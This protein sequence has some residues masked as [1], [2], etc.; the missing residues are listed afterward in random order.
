M[1]LVEAAEIG[2]KR[3]VERILIEGKKSLNGQDEL[4]A[5]TALI[6]AA[7]NGHKE[8]CEMILPKGCNV[9][10]QNTVF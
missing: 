4:Y 8:I 6:R 9:D 7:R 2:D 3:E 1:A 10:I 5:R